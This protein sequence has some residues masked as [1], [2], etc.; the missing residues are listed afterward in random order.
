MY[1]RILA[2]VA[3]LAVL[4]P[5][6]AGCGKSLDAE[7]LPNQRP[8]IRLTQAP[9][10]S[11]SLNYYAYRMN[12]VGFD[13]DGRV[14][15]YLYKID[16]SFP[17]QVDQTWIRT[18]KN[19][20]TIFFSAAVPDSET[21][22]DPPPGSGIWISSEF[23]RFAIVAVDN[24][25]EI[26][27]PAY[28]AFFSK[29]V[30][31]RVSITD[32]RPGSAFLPSVPPS[33]RFTWTGVDDDGV[34]TQKPVRYK[35]RLFTRSNPDKPSVENFPNWATGNPDSFRALYEP[36][37]PGWQE[38]NAE[39]TTASYTNLTPTEL[40][41]FVVTGY[42]EAG[43]YDPD[44]DSSK[45]MYKFEV[46]YAGTLGPVLTM[47]NEFFNY[48]Y[49]GGGYAVDPS[50]W[51]N[52]E[53][54]ADQLV[55][56][57]WVA[58][59]PPGGAVIRSYR[60]AMAGGG[61]DFELDD[62]TPRWNEQL[63]WFHW[64]RR[65]ANT[66]FAEV[67]P[68]VVNGEVYFFYV[69]AE[70]NT[71]LRSLGIIRFVVVRPTFEKPLLFVDD[72][73]LAEDKFPNG[74]LEAPRGEWPSAAELDTFFFAVG[75]FPWR[76]Y[77]TNSPAGAGWPRLPS[78]QPVS[79]PGIFNGYAYDTIGTR[80]IGNG[81]L[82]LSVLGRYRHV[83]WYTDQ[84]GATYT[85]NPIAPIAP[86]TSLRRLTSPGNPSTF[87]TWIKQG[88]RAW[89]FGG[90]AAYATLVSWN[91]NGTSTDIYT[92]EDL[93][94]I[95][96]RFMYDFAHWRS[97][98][99]TPT[100][101][102]RVRKYVPQNYQSALDPAP[103]RHWQWRDEATAPGRGWP[104]QP[105]YASLPLN[106]NP[107]TTTT[108]LLPPRVASSNFYVNPFD[109][110]AIDTRGNFIREDAD[111]DPNTPGEISTLDTLYYYNF[112]Q[113]TG[114]V[115]TLYHG[116]DIGRDS[117]PFGSDPGDF[118]TAENRPFVFSGFPLWHFR[119]TQ[120]LP[121]ADWVLQTLWGLPR[122]PG[123]PRGVIPP[124]VTSQ[125]AP[126]RVATGAQRPAPFGPR[127]PMGMQ[128]TPGPRAPRAPVGKMQPGDRR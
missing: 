100:S 97:Q 87:S 38:S 64:S 122:D 13:P 86:I 101:G 21:S 99:V 39:S 106:L 111:G 108:D 25:G 8:S 63:D 34:F 19:E 119:R 50:R 76:G 81:V 66:T 89:V 5:I 17:L 52:I 12:W 55:R 48:T 71:G 88:G 4:V 68:F 9:I 26:S 93:E 127:S 124:R 107:R 57:N 42:D 44:F 102:T 27:D 61:H 82:P 78:G 92:D 104:G 20:E 6:V 56:F 67:G 28:R 126:G 41:L 58:E 53:V 18:Q 109:V 32:P 117:L 90:G 22:T 29:T 115:M 51:V 47:F 7:F 62:E 94:L 98:V 105:S 72:T 46:S 77:P 103:P 14:D 40:H 33:V 15:Y 11:T 121:L 59:P 83:V 84:T 1:T 2:R 128:Q 120:I 74:Q 43:A 113:A 70:D 85:G 116:R 79:V 45:N 118:L 30:A 49:T 91:R 54:P 80:G 35:F 69:E 24:N 37:F 125:P 3:C 95:P 114:P 10:D 31:P 16:A 73:R 75:G 96:G 65:S 112:S 123:V 23:H 110:E 36:D 60:W